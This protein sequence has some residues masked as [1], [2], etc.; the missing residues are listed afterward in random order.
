ML[1]FSIKC[2]NKYEY[3]KINIYDSGLVSGLGL[4]LALRPTF[5]SL[6]LGLDLET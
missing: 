1:L 5:A 3:K 4:G 2:V 6:G